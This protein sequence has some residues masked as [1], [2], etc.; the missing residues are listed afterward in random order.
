MK[1]SSSTATWLISDADDEEVDGEVVID[2]TTGLCALASR[3]SN[4]EST[5]MR[6]TC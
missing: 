2:E 1:A 3:T 4:V 6:R 5:W